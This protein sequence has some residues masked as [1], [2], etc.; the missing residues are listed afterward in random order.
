[1]A[2][3]TSIHISTIDAFLAGCRRH[4]VAPATI[5]ARIGESHRDLTEPAGRFPISRMGD[6]LA[7]IALE[8]RDETLGFSEPN[9]FNRA[10][11]RWT[12]QTPGDY[13]RQ[14]A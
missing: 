2:Q 9:S 13:R 6:F 3:R 8:L 7:A 12:G 1:M 14:V 4:G 5:M 10:F 11:K